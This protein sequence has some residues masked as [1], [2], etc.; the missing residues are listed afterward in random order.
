MVLHEYGFLLLH[1]N[2]LLLLSICD[3][4]VIEQLL[5]VRIVIHGT[6][7]LHGFGILTLLLRT[8]CRD[9]G[10]DLFHSRVVG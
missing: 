1:V 9:V 10:K 4:N 2:D 3:L 5:E 8:S 6:T 7:H